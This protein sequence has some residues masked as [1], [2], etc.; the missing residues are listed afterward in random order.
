MKLEG[1]KASAAITGTGTVAKV[2]LDYAIGPNR[3]WKSLPAEINGK[4]VS[5]NLPVERPLICYF[6][7]TDQRGLSISNP[8]IELQ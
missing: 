7:V 2:Q 8:H 6:Y 1:E 4:T 5:V 3:V